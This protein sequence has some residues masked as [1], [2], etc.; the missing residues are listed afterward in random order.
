[1]NQKQFLVLVILVLISGVLGWRHW[2]SQD[3]A[4]QSSNAA[5]GQKLLGEFPVNDVATIQI[6]HGESELTLARR[7]DRWRVAQ[8][9]DYPASFTEIGNLLLKLKDVKILQ[10]EPIGAAQLARME[11]VATDTNHPVLVNFLDATGQPINQLTLGKMHLRKSSGNM[12]GFDEGGFPDG[13]YVQVGGAKDRVLLISEPLSEIETNPGRWLDKSFF[14]IEKPKTIALTFPEATNSWAIQRETEFGEWQWATP[15]GADQLD[16]TKV[17][18][19]TNPFGSPSFDD[20]RVGLTPEESGLDTPTVLTVSTFEGFNYTVNIGAKQENHY[21][22][23][24]TVTADLPTQRTPAAD[25]AEEAKAAADQEFTATKTR[26]EEKLKKESAFARWTY[27]IPSWTVDSLLKPRGELL[28]D[29]APE[30][31]EEPEDRSAEASPAT[32]D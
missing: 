27:Q 9:D 19:V 32:A 21:L 15:Q 11:L 8:R 12:G 23:T 30:E 31:P 22:I 28:Q 7:E 18:S 1:M 24:V 26:L 5:L 6:Q 17:S 14:R 13:R 16:A 10:S 20:V 3:S 2:R 25:E 29:P 4:Y